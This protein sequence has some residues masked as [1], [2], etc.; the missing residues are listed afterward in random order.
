MTRNTASRMTMTAT[1]SSSL[2]PFGFSLIELL[3]VIVVIMILVGIGVAVGLKVLGGTQAKD[4][5]GV[6]EMMVN[7]IMTYYDAEN[8]YPGSLGGSRTGTHTM[9]QT[10]L[11]RYLIIDLSNNPETQ[12]KLI[13]DLGSYIKHIDTDN[14]GTPDTY[15]LVDAWDNEMR[16]TTAGVGNQPALISAGEDGKFGDKVKNESGGDAASGDNK[17]PDSEDNIRSD[18]GM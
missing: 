11:S 4:T 16:Y 3:V 6:Q 14:D 2:R 10:S 7:A 1:K 9:K 17:A 8:Q 18:A 12:K 5:A 15:I 13:T